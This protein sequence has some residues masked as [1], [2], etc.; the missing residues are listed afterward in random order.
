MSKKTQKDNI[1]LFYDYGI[2]VEHRI[3][4][5]G[6]E[7]YDFNDNETGTDHLMA[8][9]VIKGL[10]LLDLQ[11]IDGNS[12]ITIMMNNLGGF[13]YHG[14][15]I[16]D[17]IRS[18]TNPVNIIAYG[19]CMSMGSIIFQAANKRIIAP[20]CTMMI[21][22]GTDGY[23]GHTQNFIKSAEE[24]K[25]MMGIFDEIYLAK[26]KQKDNN[27]TKA[28]VRKMLEFDTFLT[29]EQ[30]VKLGLADEILTTNR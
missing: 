4:Y 5:M 16:Y 27:V 15:A 17:A 19:H 23:V 14:L 30:A 2:N 7:S 24:A 26:M 10:L 20:N 3:L 8:E 29:A 11:D 9:R 22:D 25:R 13:V 21:H 18:C 28:K 6:S 1:E 12:P